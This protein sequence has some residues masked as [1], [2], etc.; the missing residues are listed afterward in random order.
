MY[1]AFDILTGLV[2]KIKPESQFAKRR[3]QP[4]DDEK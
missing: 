4:I 2:H 3:N 1:F